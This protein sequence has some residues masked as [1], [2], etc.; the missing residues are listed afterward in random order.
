MIGPNL[1][2]PVQGG[3]D[4]APQAESGLIVVGRLGLS[5]D[6][7]AGVAPPSAARAVRIAT[8]VGCGDGQRAHDAAG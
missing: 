8:V 7:D 6:E 1:A 2:V 3:A 4:P 5:H